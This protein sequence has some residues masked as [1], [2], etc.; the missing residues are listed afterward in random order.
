LNTL[1]YLSLPYVEKYSK[2][3][4]KDRVI[5]KEVEEVN[6]YKSVSDLNSN[7]NFDSFFGN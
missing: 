4:L 1:I 5:G 3:L 2:S 6:S 7:F